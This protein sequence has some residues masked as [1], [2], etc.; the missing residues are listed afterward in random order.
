MLSAWMSSG[1]YPLAGARNTCCSP[2]RVLM[3]PFMPPYQNHFLAS[4]SSWIACSSVVLRTLL[5]N[6][7][8]LW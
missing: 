4:M 2:T 3:A 8:M 5:M 7:V 1:G 6:Q